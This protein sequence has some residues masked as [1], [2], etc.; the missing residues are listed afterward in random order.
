MI[1]GREPSAYFQNFQHFLKYSPFNGTFKKMK[2]VPQSSSSQQARRDSAGIYFSHS[3]SAAGGGG[4]SSRVASRYFAS[5][6]P[7]YLPPP[8]SFSGA[9]AENAPGLESSARFKIFQETCD[10]RCFFQS[11]DGLT[12]GGGDLSSAVHFLSE[13]GAVFCMSTTRT[14]ATTA[15]TNGC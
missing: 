6:V 10:G 9:D 14:S 11:T 8:C 5:D 7:P 2:C 3:P 1:W 13:G 15:T 4:D 12:G